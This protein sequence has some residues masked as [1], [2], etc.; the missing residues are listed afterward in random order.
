MKLLSQSMT[1]STEISILRNNSSMGKSSQSIARLKKKKADYR[2]VSH[3][4]KIEQRCTYSW[5]EKKKQEDI[6]QNVN[7]GDFLSA[8][9]LFFCVL[10]V[11]FKFSALNININLKIKTAKHTF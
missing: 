1:A 10:Y 5:E 2:T 7:T 4:E 6:N 3:F 9:L 8:R 11:F